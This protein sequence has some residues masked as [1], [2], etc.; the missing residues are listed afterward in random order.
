MCI[1]CRERFAQK[2]LIRLQKNGDKASLFVGVGRSFYVCF[3]CLNSD[4]HLLNK[5]SGRLKIDK[6]SLEEVIKEFRN[7]VKN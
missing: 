7:N 1:S 3:E 4:K 2:D 5:I 6:N